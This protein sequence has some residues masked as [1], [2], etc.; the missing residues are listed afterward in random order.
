MLNTKEPYDICT[1]IW[2][3]VGVKEISHCLVE[4][5][6]TVLSGGEERGSFAL[7]RRALRR[8]IK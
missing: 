8:V 7:R 5:A 3:G 4:V 1:V 6:L 2:R